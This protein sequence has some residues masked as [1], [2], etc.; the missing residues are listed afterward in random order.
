MRDKLP[1]VV[2]AGRFLTGNY[3][4]AHGDQHGFFEVGQLRLLSSGPQDGWEHVSV[5]MHTRTPTWAHM[6]AVKTWFW[7]DD[8]VVMQLHPAKAN[9]VNL[10][11][12]CL[13]LW[14]PIEGVIP[15]PPLEML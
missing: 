4:S 6:C 9:Y 12:Y 7:T 11:P 3:A 1:Q 13:H 8:E 5:S 2:E 10:H 15:L 14:R